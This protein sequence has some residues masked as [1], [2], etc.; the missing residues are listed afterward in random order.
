MGCNRLCVPISKDVKGSQ[1]FTSFKRYSV[2]AHA[3]MCL[4]GSDSHPCYQE[5]DDDAKGC[6]NRAVLRFGKRGGVLDGDIPYSDCD[7][8]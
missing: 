4:Y 1:L 6:K 7:K 5:D 2:S 3:C 8:P